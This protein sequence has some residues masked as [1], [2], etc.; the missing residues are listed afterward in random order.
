MRKDGLFAGWNCGPEGLHGLVGV[1]KFLNFLD[2]GYQDY[3]EAHLREIFSRYGN[4]VDGIFHDILFF[5]TK[6]CWSE[7]SIRFR[8]KHG[9][10][11]DDAATFERFQGVAQRSFSEKFT[12]VIRSLKPDVSIFYN[13]PMKGI[14]I[15]WQARARAHRP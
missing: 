1:W 4:S 5:D 2:P 6:A 13:A 8:E 10:M 7:A 15:H 3:I 11:T 9:L 14:W 12:K